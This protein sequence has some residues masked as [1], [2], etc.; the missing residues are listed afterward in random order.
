[1]IESPLRMCEMK[2]SRY[3]GSVAG[4]SL[5]NQKYHFT[6]SMRLAMRLLSAVIP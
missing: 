2:K 1:M 3:T 5:K 6:T 4:L